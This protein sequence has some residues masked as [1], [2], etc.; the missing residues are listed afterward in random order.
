M[1]LAL[2]ALSL[3]GVERAMG[4]DRLTLALFAASVL[5]MP[6]VPHQFFPASDRPELLVDLDLPQNASIY[7]S[8]NVAERFDAVLKGDPD[9]A[10]WST[11]VG[12]APF[13]STC[14]WTLSSRTI[15]SP[16][17]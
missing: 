7:A 16:R 10:R 11:Y 9:V 12:A 3:D 5:A 4:H 6:L 14:R 17:R 13:A 15:S 1:L 2:S 8:E